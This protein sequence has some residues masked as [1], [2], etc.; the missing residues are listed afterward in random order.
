LLNK[1]FILTFTAVFITSS[2]ALA[3]P[4]DQFNIS[5]QQWNVKGSFDYYLHDQESSQLLSRVS[6]PQNQNMSILHLKYT[7]NDKNYVKFQYGLTSSGSKG[8]G[9]DSDW[10]TVG[11]SAMTDYGTMNF[12]GDQ[13]IVAID[14]GTVVSKSDKKKTSIFVGW[15]K[16]DTTN[17]ITNVIYHLIG[18]TNVGNLPQPDNGSYLNGTFSGI[19]IGVENEYKL[20]GKMSANSGLSASYL[21]TKAYGHW[22]NHFPAW[23]WG[24]S[25]NTVGYNLNLGLLYTFHKNIVA[26][27]GYY[28]SYAKMTDGKESLNYNNGISSN[29][30]GIDLGYKQRGYYIALNGKI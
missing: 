12:N 18:G 20:N 29:Y 24:N 21:T 23:D 1:T 19:H 5:L 11:S 25:G 13:K 16:R 27:I 8:E 17:Q 26:E 15:D 10:Q 28:Y 14:F 7:L 30:S 9:S 4:Q 3:A 2:L 6:M 22:A